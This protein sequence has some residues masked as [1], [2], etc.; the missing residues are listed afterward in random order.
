MPQGLQV[1]DASGNIIFD[2][3]TYA[4]RILDIITL[5]GSSSGNV[6]NS[7]LSTGTPFWVWQSSTGTYFQEG[8]V[9]TISGS[10]ISWDSYNDGFLV[11]GVY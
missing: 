11:Y 1:M 3:N 5:T 6:T 4:G 7:G 9:V 2:T 8:P 10:V